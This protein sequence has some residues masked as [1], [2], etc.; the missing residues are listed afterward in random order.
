MGDSMADASQ[1]C[2]M[3][4]VQFSRSGTRYEPDRADLPPQT[5][6]F[7]GSITYA[8]LVDGLTCL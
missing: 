5:D 8:I 1:P 2:Q 3:F 6:R 4:E 7:D